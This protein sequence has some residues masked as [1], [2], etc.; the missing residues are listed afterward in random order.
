MTI[1]TCI[2]GLNW[3]ICPNEC[4]GW[5]VI[6]GCHNALVTRRSQVRFLSPAP[7]QVPAKAT[8]ISGT[9]VKPAFWRF[10]FV[11]AFRRISIAASR[12]RLP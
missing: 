2:G 4:W 7:V 5:P 11:M 6:A 8:K 3:T 12:F 9:P 10:F 1:R